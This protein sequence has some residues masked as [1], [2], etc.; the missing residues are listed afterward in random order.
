MTYLETLQNAAKQRHTRLVNPSNAVDDPGIDLKAKRKPPMV[1]DLRL[2]P[3]TPY[4]AK[5]TTPTP[6]DITRVICEHYRV[7]PEAVQGSSRKPDL[8]WPRQVWA[9]LARE[10][11]KLSTPKIGHYLGGRDHTT[12]MHAIEKISGLAGTDAGV[13][14]ELAVLKAQISRLFTIRSALVCFDPREI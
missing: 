6:G 2:G 4:L 7:T 1:L 14:A 9:Y 8:V 11:L 3:V 12:A 13:A 5:R 10:L